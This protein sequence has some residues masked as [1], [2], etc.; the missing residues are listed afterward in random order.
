M[1]D[2]RESLRGLKEPLEHKY[3]KNT[4]VLFNL[5]STPIPDPL[6]TPESGFASGP[7]GQE[8]P[9]IIHSH[10]VPE[11]YHSVVDPVLYTATGRNK[12][13]DLAVGRNIK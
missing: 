6:V 12:L 3:I 11:F 4:T 5:C 13:Y 7:A 10:I 1:E 8:G 2:Q 9:Q